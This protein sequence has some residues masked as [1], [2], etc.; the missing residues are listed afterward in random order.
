VYVC[1]I[2]RDR[3]PAENEQVTSKAIPNIA[4]VRNPVV[5]FIASFWLSFIEARPVVLIV[6]S[7]RF[8]VGGLFPNNSG[9]TLERAFIGQA[10][11]LS[12]IWA[13]YLLNGLSDVAGDRANRS[14]RPLAAGRLSTRAAVA[15]CISLATASI[16]VSILLGLRFSIV[17]GCV[18]L[19]GAAY[20]VGPLPLKKWGPAGLAVAAAGGFLSYFAGAISYDRSIDAQLVIFALAAS[21]WI[22]FIGHSKDLGDVDGDRLA[23]RR[24]LPIVIGATKTRVVIA[25]SGILIGLFSVFAAFSSPNL[26]A[27]GIYAPASLCLLAVLI[28]AKDSSRETVRRPYA[29]F[30]ITQYAVNSLTL[31][32]GVLGSIGLYE[33][34][35]HGG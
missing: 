18:L 16:A 26:I 22:L 12:A 32:I 13:I 21:L 35:T 20:S 23:G 19:L 28:K 8:A 25:V 33:R 1:H 3:R 34:G 15:W 17:V 4:A 30:M 11:W 31:I 6:F 14:S 10:C 9:I 5:P 29:V 7:L 2:P 24:T 27:V